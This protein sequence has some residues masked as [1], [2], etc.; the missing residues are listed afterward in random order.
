VGDTVDGRVIVGA[1]PFAVFE[2][3]INEMLALIR[4]ELFQ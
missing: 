2:T 1:Q 3:A 4:L